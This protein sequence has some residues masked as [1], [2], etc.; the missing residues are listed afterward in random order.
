ME[1]CYIPTILLS[2]TTAIIV[3]LISLG[4]FVDRTFSA[5]LYVGM[6]LTF[7]LM[8]YSLCKK[9]NKLL[10]WAALIGAYLCIM[11][12]P[13]LIYAYFPQLVFNPSSKQAYPRRQ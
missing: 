2:I 12:L 1:S 13:L 6:P 9:G 8:C 4:F 7:A 3:I 11:I 10:A 5:I